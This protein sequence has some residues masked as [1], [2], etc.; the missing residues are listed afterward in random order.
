MLFWSSL[1]LFFIK[2]IVYKFESISNFKFLESFIAS[3][4][5]SFSTS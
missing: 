4:E 3:I 2:I 5:I 1:Y